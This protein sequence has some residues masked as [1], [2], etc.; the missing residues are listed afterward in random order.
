MGNSIAV[1]LILDYIWELA[2]EILRVK[3]AKELIIIYYLILLIIHRTAA[4]GIPA[5]SDSI[6]KDEIDVE[7]CMLALSTYFK[8]FDLLEAV[9]PV[10]WSRELADISKVFSM[11]NGGPTNKVGQAN[12]GSFVRSSTSTR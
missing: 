2:I 3:A 7:Y 1:Y 8:S 10:P 9:E 5:T 12:P 4:D 11:N 6:I